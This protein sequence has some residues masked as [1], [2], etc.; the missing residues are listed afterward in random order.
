V[1]KVTSRKNVSSETSK[2]K[3]RSHLRKTEGKEKE[4]IALAEYG[5]KAK[6]TNTRSTPRSEYWQEEL[7]KR[8]RGEDKRDPTPDACPESMQRSAV[9]PLAKWSHEIRYMASADKKK[10]DGGRGE[11]V[12]FSNRIE[13]PTV[14]RKEGELV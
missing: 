4:R 1:A 13:S 7:K 10:K 6:K 3:D 2:P 11:R 14:S 8:K 9:Q 12:D 5:P